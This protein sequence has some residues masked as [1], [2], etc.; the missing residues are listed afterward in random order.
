VIEWPADEG[1][2]SGGGGPRPLTAAATDARPADDPQARAVYPPALRG[3]LPPPGGAAIVHLGLPALANAQPS[4]TRRVQVGAFGDALRAAGLIAAAFGDARAALLLADRRGVVPRGRLRTTEDAAGSTTPA[5]WSDDPA[6]VVAVAVLDGPALDHLVRDALPR[7]RAGAARVLVL[8]LPVAGQPAPARWSRLGFV[9]AAGPEIPAGSLLVSPTTRTPGLVANVDVAP[10]VLAWHGAPIPSGFAGRPFRAVPHP[11]PL[12]AA[13]R[14]DRQTT[15]T[16]RATV[17][18]L[19]GYGAFA[20]GAGLAALFVL[21]RRRRGATGGGAA[22]RGALLMAAA[23]LV[24]F[25]PVGVRVPATAPAYGLSVTAI[26]AALAAAAVWI[27]RALR[28]GGDRARAAPALGLLLTATAVIVTADAALGSPLVSRALL[29]G[30]YLPASAST[31][32]G[33]ST[34]GS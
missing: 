25:L 29:S 34:W 23:A 9:A 31:A 27:G 20:I 18:V 22:A 8:G 3:P 10:T 32:S 11:D 17:P 1:D 28:G 6:D 21:L 5:G 4:A 33:T 30:Y 14:L 16:A 26:S 24:A 13:G 12:A 19:V 15:A 7:A 2:G